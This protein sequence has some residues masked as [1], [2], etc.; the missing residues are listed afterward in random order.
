MNKRAR[1]RPLFLPIPEAIPWAPC[2]DFKQQRLQSNGL[3]FEK[4]SANCPPG[5]RA[6]TR[7]SSR[8]SSPVSPAPTSRA[9]GRCDLHLSDASLSRAGSFP[10]PGHHSVSPIASLSLETP[11]SHSHLVCHWLPWSQTLSLN[12]APDSLWHLVLL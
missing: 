12:S 1:L 3:T 7:L 10:H 5:T 6:A 11:P 2:P 8:A 4:V 9:G